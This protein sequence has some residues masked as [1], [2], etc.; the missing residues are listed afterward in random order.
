MPILRILVPLLLLVGCA[1]SPQTSPETWS[2]R[3]PPL[4][5]RDAIGTWVLTDERNN[6]YNVRLEPGGRMIST[7]AYGPDGARGVRGEWTL[8]GGQVHVTFDD[9]WRDVLRRGPYGVEK[10]SWAPGV[11]LAATPNAFGQAMKLDEPIVEYVGVWQ[12]TSALPGNPVFH[13]ALQSNRLA[14]KTIDE[15]RLGTCFHSAPEKCVRIQWAN[16]FSDRIRRDRDAYVLETWLPGSD[17]TGPP[18]RTSPA[19]RC[20]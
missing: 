2:R 6:T 13:I 18:D 11:D 16:G 12:V 10:V 14:F 17:R 1:A 5:D 19:V 3:F 15:I 4:L 8:A 9:G 20:E 7:W